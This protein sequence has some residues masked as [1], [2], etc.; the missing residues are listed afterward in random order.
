MTREEAKKI[1]LIDIE[2]SI[3]KFGEDA[4][5]V[6]SPKVGKNYWTWKEYRE[7]VVNDTDLD[8]CTDSNPIDTLINY[9]KYRLERGLMSLVDVFLKNNKE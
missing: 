2:K 4:T 5:A 8:D 6:M 7:A 3:K 1:L 9:D